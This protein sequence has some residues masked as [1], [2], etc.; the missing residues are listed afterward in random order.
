MRTELLRQTFPEQIAERLVDYIIVENLKP[1]DLLPSTAKLAEDFGVSR[2]VVREAL[3]ALVGQGI[4]ETINGKGALVKPLDSES[5]RLF[6][7]RAVQLERETIIELMEI[8]KPLE[9]QSATLAAQRR[10]LEDLGRL[11]EIVVSMR[12]HLPDLE[13]YANLDVEFHMQIASASHNKMM[14]YLIASIRDSLKDA[15][16][17]GLRRRN[18]TEQLERVQALH[19]TIL[20]AIEQGQPGQAGAAMAQHFDEAVMALVKGEG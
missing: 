8:R 9:I 20:T 12:E 18:T 4:I 7:Q 3:K 6:F 13:L 10:T 19:E 1:G 15:I 11:H 14:A 5:L 17:E 2:P 16:L